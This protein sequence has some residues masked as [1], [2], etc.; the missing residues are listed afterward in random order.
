VGVSCHIA[1]PVALIC[2]R[3]ATLPLPHWYSF[4]LATEQ[5]HVVK[6]GPMAPLTAALQE[7]CSKFRPALDPGRCLVQYSKKP[8]DMNTPFRLL[9]IPAGSKLEVIGEK[10]TLNN[11]ASMHRLK[12]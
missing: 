12:L 4:L 8:V 6:V 1:G 7:A 5:K 2:R 9:N 11:T 10:S 3:V